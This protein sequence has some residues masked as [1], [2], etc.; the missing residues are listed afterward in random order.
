MRK[1]AG[2]FTIGRMA[3]RVF[4]DPDVQR[5]SA[6][7]AVRVMRDALRAAHEGRLSAPPR[8]RSQLDDVTYTFTVGAVADAFSGFRAYRVGEPAGDQLVAAWDAE[9]ALRCV[10][11]GEELGARRTG[12]LGAVAA[13]VLALP[14]ADTVAVIGSGH[15]AWTQLWALQAV[16][17]LRIVRVY[18]PNRAHRDRFV[19]AAVEDL[20]I[21]ATAVSSAREAAQGADVI[22]LATRS[23][24]PVIDAADVSPG[25]HVTTV[26]PKTI[27]AHETPAGLVK[28]AALVTCDSPSQ[29]RSYAAPFFTGEQSSS[30]SARFS[31]GRRAGAQARARSRCIARSD[32]PEPKSRSPQHCSTP[33]HRTDDPSTLPSAQRPPTATLAAGRRNSPPPTPRA[34]A[35]SYVDLAARYASRL[36]RCSLASSS[37]TAR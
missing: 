30:T 18:S 5:L 25:A 36:K 2:V 3:C 6:A 32:W 4:G 23:I 1:R 27:D 24:T 9:G 12:A 26:G 20:G 35:P 28:A 31:A 16:R 11:V 7:V 14:D 29:A 17:T 22:V 34:S 37:T 19:R 33:T 21:D 10:V 13:D 8:V 15:Q